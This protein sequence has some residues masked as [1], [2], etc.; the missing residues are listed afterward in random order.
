MKTETVSVAEVK[1]HLSEYVAKS[2]YSDSRIIITKRSR[3]VAA[4][5]SLIDLQELEQQDKRKGLGDVIGKWDDFE[6]I[7][8]GVREAIE[9]RKGEGN[10]R[11]VSL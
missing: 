8:G 9:A 5:V 4:L 6:E 10:G 11:H 3:P 7:A 1:A 2:A